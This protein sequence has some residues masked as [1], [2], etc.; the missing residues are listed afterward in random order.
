MI[1]Y[2]KNRRPIHVFDLLK[3]FHYVAARR[4]KMFMYKQVVA[5]IARPNLPS[6]L[7]ISHLQGNKERYYLRV[8]GRVLP[9]YEIVQ[10]YTGGYFK[11]REK[12]P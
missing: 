10:G 8:D 7:E 9:D 1:L 11:D 5:V 12:K 2:D 3:V 6:L 4:E